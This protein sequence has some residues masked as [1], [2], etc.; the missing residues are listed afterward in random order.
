MKYVRLLVTAL[1]VAASACLPAVASVITTWN[2][3]YSGT[4]ATPGGSL[5]SVLA[6][7][8]LTVDG[9]GSS[10]SPILS[11]S[12]TRNGVAIAQLDPVGSLGAAP[13]NNLFEAPFGFDAFGWAYTLTNGEHHYISNTSSGPSDTWVTLVGVPREIFFN[14]FAAKLVST[15]L[16]GGGGGGGSSVPEPG[17]LLLVIAAM[18][19]ASIDFLKLKRNALRQKVWQQQ[20][21]PFAL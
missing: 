16:G 15:D 12:G 20:Q 6:S 17:T 11:F 19:L 14:N 7:G 21:E 3:S 18:A 9:D 4:G 13:F 2:W 10:F 1:V 5:L 8:Q